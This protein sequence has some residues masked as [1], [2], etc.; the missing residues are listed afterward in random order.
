MEIGFGN[1]AITRLGFMMPYLLRLTHP[2][3]V[4]RLLRIEETSQ[5]TI[6]NIKGAFILLVIGYCS[7]LLFVLKERKAFI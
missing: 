1:F 5:I 2:E 7:A 4:E 3:I 6:E